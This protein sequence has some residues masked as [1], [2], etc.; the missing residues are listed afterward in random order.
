VPALV[1]SVPVLVLEQVQVP[2]LVVSVPVLVPEQESV[3]A[4]ELE[5]ELVSK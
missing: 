5:W 2:A 1:V 3:Q 4:P